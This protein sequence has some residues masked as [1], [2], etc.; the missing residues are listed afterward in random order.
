MDIASAIAK[1]TVRLNAEPDNAPRGCTL[2]SQNSACRELIKELF[3]FEGWPEPVVADSLD[4]RTLQEIVIIEIFGVEDILSEVRKFAHSIPHH[5]GVIIFGTEDAISTMRGLKELGFY[6]V[7]WPADKQ[8]L[9]DFIAHVVRNQRHLRG[10]SKNRIAKEIAVIGTKGGIGTSMLSLELGAQMARKGS[11]TVLVDYKYENSD[12]DV[13]LGQAEFSRFDV[14]GLE[15]QMVE[16]DQHGADTY[17]HE[18]GRNYNLLALG[19]DLA[20]SELNKYT[21]LLVN[22]LQRQVH[23]IFK[24][25][26]GSLDFPLDIPRL[27]RDNHQIVVLIEPSI[28]SVRRARELL[29]QIE[30]YQFHRKRK[31]RVFKVLNFHRPDDSFHL[32]EWEVVRF[33]GAE[34]DV[35][36]GFNKKYC[37][38]LLDG[39]RSSSLLRDGNSPFRQLASLIAGKKRSTAG[40]L[41]NKLKRVVCL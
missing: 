27:C 37:R 3:R 1:N 14:G 6:Y 10:V 24:D 38:S 28:A 8:E 18:I 11:D 20:I 19:A 35:T 17:L 12:V 9:A 23:F 25:Y 21:E 32:S 36:I 22:M 31:V 39:D 40:G 16:Q 30:D 4:K 33:L 26:S 5:T 7:L 13:L 29:K 2:L 41:T 34:P 15:L